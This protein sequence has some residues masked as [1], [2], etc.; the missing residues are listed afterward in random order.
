METKHTP[1]PWE[2]VGRA[3]YTAHE[4][5]SREI[6][7]DGHNTRSAGNDEQLANARLIAAAPE[8]LEACQA[9]IAWD[10]AENNAKPYSDDNGV[11]FMGR[12]GLCRKAFQM[13][14]AAIQKATATHD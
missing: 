6:I 14:R 1:G 10:D 11:S 3:V 13:A 8:L 2:S 4:N 9:M 5:P 12:I 7:W